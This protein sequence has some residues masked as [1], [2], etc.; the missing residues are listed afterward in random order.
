MR[1]RLLSIAFASML[2]LFSTM[3]A[4]SWQFVGGYGHTGWQNQTYYYYN[5]LGYAFVGKAGFV[6]SNAAGDTDY[7]YASVLLIDSLSHGTNPGFETG[8]YTDWNPQSIY[9][10]VSNSY[11][12]GV[13]G[14]YF[15]TQSSGYLSYQEAYDVSTTTF[16]NAFGQQGSVGN[17]LE[18]STFTLTSGSQF[19]FDWAFLAW[20]Q[21]PNYD[22]A[23]F[24]LTG[25]M[26]G[27]PFYE[28]IGLAQIVPLPSTALL[29]GSAL[30]GLGIL[31]RRVKR[32]KG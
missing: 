19:S 5:P 24:Y 26:D 30:L 16:F 23:K 8:D 29:F 14:Y 13:H 17:I 32:S 4:A 18:S 27:N 9:G 7:N 3:P 2:V 25:T 11:Y 10:G 15:P 28:E 21:A 1:K 6:V 22:F 20:D 31:G 12:S